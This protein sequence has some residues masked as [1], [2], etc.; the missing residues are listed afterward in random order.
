MLIPLPLLGIPFA[1][2]N[3]SQ[4]AEPGPQPQAASPIRLAETMDQLCQRPR[5]AG[6]EDSQAA[7]DYAAQ[8]MADAGFEVE[9]APY[10]CY[11]PR[12]TEQSLQ[13]QTA[14]GEWRALDMREQGYAEDPRSLRDHIPPMHGLTAPG[15]AEGDLWYVG[16]G[17]EAEFQ[18]LQKKF[19]DAFVGGIALIR[20]GALYRGLKVAHAEA[21]GFRAALLYTDREDDGEVVGPVLPK[22]PWRP[23]TGIQRGSVY[24]ADGDPLTP[25]WAAL[26]HA[27]RILPSQAQGMVHIPSLPISAANAALLMAGAKRKLGPLPSKVRLRIKQDPNL[28]Q[29][30]NV[31]GRVEG[32][33]HPEEWV[34]VGAHRDAWGFGA[35]DNGTGTTVLLETVRVFGEALQRGWR[36]DRTLIFAT[37]DAEEWGLVGSTE[38][39]EQYRDILREKAVAYVNMDVAATGPNFGA[40]CTPGLVASLSQVCL[41]QGIDAPK[42]LGIPGGG[43]DHVP[44]LELAGVE[45]VAFGFHG[46]NGV[47]HSALDTPYL[48]E[49]FLDPDYQY[50]AQAAA[51]AVALVKRLCAGDCVVDGRRGWMQQ[52]VQALDR[53]PETTLEETLDKLR[54]QREALR[55]SLRV[56]QSP[57]SEMGYRFPRF[58]LPPE[59]RSFLWRTAGY[60]SDW[61]PRW[62]QASTEGDADAKKE[63]LEELLE[64][65]KKAG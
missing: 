8:V 7:I 28:V 41:S 49:K 61:F 9:I 51:F 11:L 43:S 24:N 13:M 32:A 45:V 42:K 46:G 34:I 4:Q 57:L 6:S 14:Q 39:V 30:Q 54:L 5:L 15:R 65:L 23:P 16:Y 10:W 38:W 2:A 52:V 27:K 33:T 29:I 48:V 60:G 58:F 40:S 47:Y 17:T 12:Q 3:A 53:L 25:G 1:L 44:F 21:F 19:G 62:K 35:T 64:G 31:L 22:G 18:Q 59:G 37:W 50:H 20:Y 63:A 55:L 36:P 26:E 56:Q